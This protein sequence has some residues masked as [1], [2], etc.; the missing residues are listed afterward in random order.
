MNKIQQI[1]FKMFQTFYEQ[2]KIKKIFENFYK[3]EIKIKSKKN[4]LNTGS[5]SRGSFELFIG[6][7]FEENIVTLNS[8]NGNVIFYF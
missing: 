7:A 6:H 4:I 5:K 3:E 8:I 2:K 1:V